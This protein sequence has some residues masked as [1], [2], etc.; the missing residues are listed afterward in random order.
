MTDTRPPTITTERVAASG[1]TRQALAL[2][3]DDVTRDY[4]DLEYSAMRRD[5]VIASVLNLYRAAVVSDDP[6]LVPAVTNSDADG[7]E[8]A[9]EITNWI[10]SQLEDLDSPLIDS[11][12]TIIEEGM[13]YGCKISEVVLRQDATYTGRTQV[14]LHAIKPKPRHAAALGI[15]AYGNVQSIWANVMDG[16]AMRADLAVP[17]S[18]LTTANIPARI[19]R[20]LDPPMPRLGASTMGT[21]S[22]STE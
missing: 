9:S 17:R 7:Y 22:P 14:V 6:Q 15:D 1:G 20:R 10:S 11:L 5:A 18:L 8:L 12:G 21:V 19:A 4:S 13:A 3:V 2:S 16:A